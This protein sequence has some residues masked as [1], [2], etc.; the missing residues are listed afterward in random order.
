MRMR[1][2]LAS[3]AS[4]MP[5]LPTTTRSIT[6]HEPPRRF[7]PA[8]GSGGDGR[9]AHH[10]DDTRTKFGNPWSSFRFQE[11]AQWVS[12]IYN[13]AVHSPPVPPDIKSAIPTQ[14]PTWGHAPGTLHAAKATWLGHACYLVELP[15][16][17]G[18]ARGPRIIFDPV[19]SKRCSPSKLLGPARYTDPPCKVEDVPPVDLIVLSHN[20]YDH[21]DIPTLRAL[22]PTPDRTRTHPHIFVPLN[23]ATPLRP[24]LP[25]PSS[26]A[27]EPERIHELDWWDER[28]VRLSLPGALA[29]PGREKAPPAVEAQLRITCAPSQHTSGRT[30]LD[31][32]AALWAAW[33]VYFAGDTGYRT[34]DG[35]SEEERMEAL[36]RAAPCCPAFREAGE[37]FGGVDVALVP[38]GAYAPRAMWSNLHASPADAVRIMQDVRARRALAMHWGTWVLTTEPVLEPPALLRRECEKAGVGADEFLVP[39]LGETVLF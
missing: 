32:W 3:A 20:H 15:A 37:R 1:G 22:T 19:F 29:P 39:A 10:L 33:V 25:H 18:A 26:R 27:P 11:P 31:R 17:P 38:I 13:N 36:E 34:V 30:G 9:P 24:L 21:T 23:N 6:V 8:D 2:P 12:M 16:P 35:A 4:T 28:V 7:P 14:A 5:P